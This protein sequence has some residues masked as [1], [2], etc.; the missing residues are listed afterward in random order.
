[1]GSE[2]AQ[3]L[4]MNQEKRPKESR[5]D[6]VFAPENPVLSWV[7]DKMSKLYLDLLMLNIDLKVEET[8]AELIHQFIETNPQGYLMFAVNHH[9][10]DID[11]ITMFQ[12]LERAF[13]ELKDHLTI[14]VEKERFS[15]WK[16][17]FNLDSTIGNYILF[18][19]QIL[20]PS[21]QPDPSSSEN[22]KR[23]ERMQKA[24]EQIKFA[25]DAGKK[26]VFF[27]EGT[28]KPGAKQGNFAVP[29]TMYL[30]EQAPQKGA[31]M[32]ADVSLS[33]L[34]LLP[35]LSHWQEMLEKARLLGRRIKAG[36]HP[37]DKDIQVI[38][39]ELI[40]SRD[41]EGNV[42][43]RGALRRKYLEVRNKFHPNPKAESVP[44]S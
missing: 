41:E 3:F 14:V 12:A 20:N 7:R 31:V 19:R 43:S 17:R 35:K 15:Q 11:A 5:N 2:Q 40:L 22:A 29:M 25:M 30:E 39:H 38:I 34:E 36:L 1:M 26:L 21:E 27:T 4:A 33:G 42:L 28:R 44:Q 37:E 8:N 9:T 32:I 18:D 16:N 6:V 23:D 10:S 13:P 24:M